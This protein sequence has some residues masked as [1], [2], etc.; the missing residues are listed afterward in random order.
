MSGN[1]QKL[2]FSKN[3]NYFLQLKD[4]SQKEVANQLGIKLSTFNSWCT[5]VKM[6][7]MDKIQKLAEYFEIEKSDLIEDKSDITNLHSEDYIRFTALCDI[8]YRGVILWSEDKFLHEYETIVI[9]EHISELL[10]KYKATIEK[11]ANSKMY[12]NQNKDNL[13]NFYRDR[14]PALTE[15]DIKELFLKQELE[16]NLNDMTNWLNNFPG[17]IARMEESY[18][19]R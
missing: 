13:M 3:L 8:Y 2:I 10:L 4:K 18:E 19:N 16:N 15:K 14:N 7:R 17:W 6:P 11:C 5:G 9:R 1:E 12:W